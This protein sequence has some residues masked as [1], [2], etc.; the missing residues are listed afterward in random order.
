MGAGLFLQSLR[1]AH[2]IDLGFERANLL[3]LSLDLRLNGYDEPRG[4][5]LYEQ[6]LERANACPACGRRASPP[7]SPSA[8]GD[9]GGQSRSRATRPRAAR[10]WECTRT[11]S[12]PTTSARMGVPRRAGARLQRRRTERRAGGGRGQR[13]FRAALLARPG[14]HRQA[15]PPRPA[16]AGHRGARG[17][18]RREGR[19]VRD[20][21]R[22][23]DA[24]LL[25]PAS[26]SATSPRPPCTSRT[27]EIR[28]LLVGAM[29]REVQ[30][31]DPSLPVFDVKTMTD[32]LGFS[33]LR[34]RCRKGPGPLRH[35]R[36]GSRGGRDLR[37]DGPGG[38]P[39]DARAGRARRAGSAAHATSCR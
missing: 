26:G 13:G 28:A 16:P 8:S 7:A 18:R 17:R 3:L 2:R 21:R 19:E 36:P 22:G 30:L 1:Q 4:R 6:L 29:R 35:R 27:T 12:G 32:H 14:P 39:A 20:P 33:L 10:T 11:P 23:P 15:R 5:Q 34:P 31:L 25:P 37:G 24:L 38:A 9:G